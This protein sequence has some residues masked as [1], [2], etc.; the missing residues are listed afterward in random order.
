MKIRSKKLFAFLESK[1]VLDG[2]EE[3]LFEAK[4]EYRKNYKRDWKRFTRIKRKAI[5]CL[6]TISEYGDI[7][8]QAKRMGQRTAQF[9]KEVILAATHNSV[10]VPNRNEILKALQLVGMTGISLA[11]SQIPVTPYLISEYVNYLHQAEQL[12]LSILKKHTR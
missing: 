9:G 1:G 5:N 6:F 10:L 12:L 2:T 4:R 3:A 7:Q 11:N 8:N